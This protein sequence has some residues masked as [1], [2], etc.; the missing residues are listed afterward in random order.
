[1]SDIS[2]SHHPH[3]VTHGVVW[4][5]LSVGDAVGFAMA[6]WAYLR[7]S[8][9]RPLSRNEFPLASREAKHEVVRYWFLLN[10]K[11]YSLDVGPWFTLGSQHAGFGQSFL[12][13]SPV[14]AIEAIDREFGA[15]LDPETGE[16]LA[17]EFPG[18]WMW[19]APPPKI[20][21]SSEFAANEQDIQ[22]EILARLDA[23]TTELREWRAVDS[24]HGELG[25]NSGDEAPL[26]DDEHD[27]AVA[28]VEESRQAATERDWPRLKRVSAGL[29][30]VAAKL[31]SWLL[32]K[33]DL[34]IDEVIKNPLKAALAFATIKVLSDVH[35][36]DQLIKLAAAIK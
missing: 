2:A 18:R 33:F 36:L 21:N 29:Q 16:E 20:L 23:L 24:A 6:D 8:D 5:E 27:H 34:G 11:P 15:L 9:R 17:D 25:H 3:R 32:K 4:K 26:T 14:S 19:R 12:A 13:P 1:M 10:L 31:G 7:P 28:A 22:H 35:T 30:P